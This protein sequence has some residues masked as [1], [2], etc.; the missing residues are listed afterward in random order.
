M[1]V[2]WQLSTLLRLCAGA[3]A[4]AMRQWETGLNSAHLR[5]VQHVDL[6]NRST[7]LVP[8]LD[9]LAISRTSDVIVPDPRFVADDYDLDSKQTTENERELVI[10]CRGRRVPAF[11]GS[12]NL[13]TWINPMQQQCLS[14]A[15]TETVHPSTTAPGRLGRL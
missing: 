7:F 13:L 8:P 10:Y 1:S 12:M 5:L 4:P 2:V 9:Q 6:G 11:S 3:A 15:A 14:P